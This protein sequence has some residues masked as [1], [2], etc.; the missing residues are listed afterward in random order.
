MELNT[1]EKTVLGGDIGGTKTLLGTQAGTNRLAH[2]QHYEN[3]TYEQFSAVLEDYLSRHP[4]LQ[5]HDCILTLAIAGPVTRQRC[6]MTN[7]PWLIDAADLK[8]HFGFHAVY[9]L[10]DLA[11]TAWALPDQFEQDALHMLHGKGLDFSQPVAVISVGTGLGEAVL[12]PCSQ[13]GFEV[14]ATEGGHKQFAPFD[15]RSAR[16]L[17]QAFATGVPAV[18]WENWFSGT[19]LPQLFSTLYPDL[20]VPANETLTVLAQTQPH[21]P[22]GQCIALLA[23]GI[24]AEA[25]NLAL[26]SLSWGGVV[27]AGG[28]VQ[29]IKHL[30]K[31]VRHQRWFSHKAEY[32]DR[33]E[34]IPL[35]LCTDSQVALKG[36]IAYSGYQQ[37]H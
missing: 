14:L 33:L 28:V 3:R 10:N 30:I 19:G 32:T 24:F 34:Q 1:L 35:A 17:E 13:G 5:P 11:A 36:A 16:L 27:F 37:M 25:G 18:S 15:L 31:D 8:H 26:Q 23:D 20:K 22:A 29:H 6:Q 4:A 21:S 7:L 2:V 9:L 12:T